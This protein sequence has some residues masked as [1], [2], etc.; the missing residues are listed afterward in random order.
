MKGFPP[1]PEIGQVTVAET[2]G[3][4]TTVGSAHVQDSLQVLCSGYPQVTVL[5]ENSRNSVPRESAKSAFLPHDETVWKRALNA[6]YEH[7]FTGSFEELVNSK[8]DV[9]SI[10]ASTSTSC[11]TLLRWATSLN[12]SLFPHL[13]L[14]N[15]DLITKFTT[16]SDWSHS[17]IRAFAWHPHVTK[18]AYALHDDSIKV[19]SMGN[20][21][22]PV[23][24]HKLQKYVADIS[25]QPLSASVLA[26]ACQT[27]VLIWHIDPTSLAARPSASCV[28]VLNQSGH[29]PVTSLS[30]HPDASILLSA[31]PTDTAI[32]AWKVAMETGVTLRRAGGGGVSFLKF[33]PEGSKVLAAT[34]M[35]MFR[36]WDNS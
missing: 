10:I 35:S 36:V 5:P 19:H 20:T 23:L 27:C 2:N 1:P 8:D 30:W 9:P 28:Q 26:V 14:S 3:D 18:F 6:W 15:E 13:S 34:P 7:G 25:W 21:L 17:P 31:S 22:V 29:S 11:L 32:M 4:L 33:S 24:K 12:G 16:I